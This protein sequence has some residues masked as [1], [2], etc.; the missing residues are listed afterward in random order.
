M[1]KVDEGAELP[2]STQLT[3]VYIYI[4]FLSGLIY[5]WIY[6]AGGGASLKHRTEL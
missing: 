1:M 3:F 4:S 6:S 2:T 5:S